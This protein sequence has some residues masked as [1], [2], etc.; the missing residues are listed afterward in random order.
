MH[1]KLGGRVFEQL[2][3]LRRDTD[4]YF[5]TGDVIS[6]G[7]LAIPLRADDAWGRLAELDCTAS[8]PGNRESHVLESAFHKKLEGASHPL[9]CAN[10]F[11]KDGSMPLPGHL[12]L[13]R[14]GFRIGIF[15]VMV[16]IV[17]RAMKTAVASAY[18]WEA[19]IPVAVAKAAEL[20]P[21]VDLL[22]ALTHIGYAKDR[23]LIAAADQID[24]VFGGHSHSIL[25]TPERHGRT[26]LCQGGSHGRYAG[27][28]E[29]DGETLTGGLLGLSGG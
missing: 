9:L 4:L 16:P 5:D 26:F 19:A 25:E 2:R 14:G 18:L 20:R 3:G 21:Q 15:G 24:I 11:R 22:I 23:E 8:V 17:T 10:L 1:G 27:V 12:I 6:A 29:W 7:N 28:Y 13:D